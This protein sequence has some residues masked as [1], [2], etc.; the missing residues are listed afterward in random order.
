MS[1]RLATA[2]IYHFIGKRAVKFIAALLTTAFFN[3][4]ISECAMHHI[5]LLVLL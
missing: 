5:I 4:L 1:W 2:L 3:I